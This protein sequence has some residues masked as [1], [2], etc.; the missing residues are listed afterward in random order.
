[1]PSPRS[2]NYITG[3]LFNFFFIKLSNK[4]NLIYTT[5]IQNTQKQCLEFLNDTIINLRQTAFGV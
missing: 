1:M 2:K 3:L 4:Y 5:S